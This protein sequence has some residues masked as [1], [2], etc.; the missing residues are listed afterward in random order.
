MLFVFCEGNIILKYV[1]SVIII[2]FFF[3]NLNTLSD[4][5]RDLGILQLW[6]P[7]VASGG[8]MQTIRKVIVPFFFHFS[9]VMT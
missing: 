8:E 4:T 2:S 5:L 7:R 6:M 9:Q 1:G 3:Y